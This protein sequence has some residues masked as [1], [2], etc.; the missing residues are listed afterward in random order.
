MREH[1]H[2]AAHARDAVVAGGGPARLAVFLGV[3]AHAAELDHLERLAVQAH[4]LLPVEHRAA[5]VELDGQRREQHHRR[6]QRR[7]AR[8]RRRCRTR[9]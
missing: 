1:A 4:A 8:W 2:D 7:S 3:G 9:A 5:A 6:G